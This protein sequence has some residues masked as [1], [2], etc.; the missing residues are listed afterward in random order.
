[1]KG[2][3]TIGPCGDSRPGWYEIVG[4]YNKPFQDELKNRIPRDYWDF[5]GHSDPK[6]WL[7]AES[8]AWSATQIAEKHYESVE[9]D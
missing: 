6:R 4:D 2:S 8:W 9:S 5:D 7:V 1:M 3:V